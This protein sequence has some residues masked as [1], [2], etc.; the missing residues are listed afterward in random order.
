MVGETVSHYRIVEKI[1]GGGMGVVYRAEDLSLGRQ[2][3]LKFLPEK[4]A[5]DQSALERFQREA[6]AAAALN[7]PNICVVYEI[8]SHSGQPFIAMELLKGQTLRQAIAAGSLEMEAALDVAVQLADALDAAHSEGILHRDVKPANIFITERGQPKLL[9]FGLAKLTPARSASGE[10]DATHAA[11]QHITNAGTTVGTAAYMSPEQA[12]GK[13]VDARSDIFSFGLVLYEMLTGRQAFQGETAAVLHDALLNRMPPAPSSLN[14]LISAELERIL[15]KAI[16][17][18]RDLRYQHASDLRADL[19]RLRRDTSSSRSAVPR[20]AGTDSAPSASAVATGVHTSDSA[21]ATALLSRHK[22]SLGAAG[23]VV[24]LLLAAGYWY[25]QRRGGGASG[26][27]IRSVA[28]LPFENTGGNAD[29]EYLSDGVAESLLNSLAKLPDLRVISRSTAFSFKGKNQ[30]PREFGRTLGVDAVVTGRVQQRGTAL[31]ISAEMTSVEGDA[32]LW[33]ERYDRSSADL[34]SVQNE[35]LGALESVLR[36]QS[37]ATAGNSPARQTANSE[38]YQLYLRGRFLWNK[39]TRDGVQKS[40]DHFRQAVALD[41]NYA[42]AYVG[43]ADS[44]QILGGN[45]YGVAKEVY[46]PSRTAAAKALELDPTLGEARISLAMYL[47]DFERDYAAA[48]KEFQRGLAL[49]PAYSTGHQWYGNFLN[50]LG[51][52][53]EAI[54][55]NKKAVELDP[56]SPRINLNLGDSLATA[57]RFDEA[58]AQIKKAKELGDPIALISLFAAHVHSG[59]IEALFDE[60]KSEGAGPA[61]LASAREAFQRDGKFGLARVLLKPEYF[62]ENGRPS[63]QSPAQMAYYWSLSGDKEKTL[64]L[65]ER[66][67]A[68]QDATSCFFAIKIDPSWDWLRSEPRFQAVLRQLKLAN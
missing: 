32:Q 48:E 17:K 26:S 6:R 14:P 18:D 16:E 45:G 31:V 8:G 34:A 42:L 62:D 54:R 7:H 64:N 28:V 36:P 3:A 60:L 29:T 50:L 35:I 39:R 55:E 40:L 24:I 38:A 37:R 59:K 27:A 57:R 23:V 12:R 19:K 65:L 41:P 53:D 58:I 52:S 10:D 20:G 43:I 30:T 13:E 47:S 33:G 63:N 11:D 22:A 44:Y 61:L 9:D 68:V 49:S 1:G 46:P 4:F 56:L 66:A 67:I 5:Q 21:I 15:T 2:V 51:R 25:S